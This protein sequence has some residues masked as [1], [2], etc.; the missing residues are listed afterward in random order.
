MGIE[1]FGAVDITR[2]QLERTRKDRGVYS[3]S[4]Q[5]RRTSRPTDTERIHSPVY[6]RQ[7]KSPRGCQDAKTP[8]GAASNRALQA[9]S[10]KPPAMLMAIYCRLGKSLSG[11]IV[12]KRFTGFV[13]EKQL[14]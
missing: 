1:A 6:G 5:G 4:A 9:T 12:E 13:R 7:A 10:A 2:T 8:A 3:E 11:D 14:L